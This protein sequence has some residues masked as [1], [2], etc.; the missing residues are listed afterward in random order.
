MMFERDL[1]RYVEDRRV[2]VGS[3]D[4]R[5]YKFRAGL[6]EVTTNKEINFAT[7]RETFA[8]LGLAWVP[9]ELRNADG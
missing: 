2:S 7:E 1:R 4:I 6:I 3:A 5:G 9:P 8:Y